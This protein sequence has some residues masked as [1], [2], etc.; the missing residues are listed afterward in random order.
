MNT[1]TGTGSEASMCSEGAL[2]PT[3]PRAHQPG[4]PLNPAHLGFYG[5]FIAYVWLMD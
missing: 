1:Y 2:V 5:G 3:P 4:N